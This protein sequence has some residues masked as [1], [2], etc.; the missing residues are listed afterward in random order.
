MR[1]GLT[2]EWTDI[3]MNLFYIYDIQPEALTSFYSSLDSYMT[4]FSLS[5]QEM[6]IPTTTTEIPTT[7]KTTDNIV[8]YSKNIT[9]SYPRINIK[10]EDVNEVKEIDE[11][12]NSNLPWIFMSILGAVLSMIVIYIVKLKRKH[13]KRVKRKNKARAREIQANTRV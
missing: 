10:S 13:N 6:S 7:I 4:N 9:T 1:S 3:L 12:N 11:T 2:Q 5:E 8:L